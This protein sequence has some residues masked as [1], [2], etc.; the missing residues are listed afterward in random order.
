MKE[1]AEMKTHVPMNVEDFGDWYGFVI[2]TTCKTCT[3]EDYKQCPGRRVL[4]TYDV[5]AI[6]PGAVGKC[7]YSYVGTPEAEEL[8]PVDA[9]VVPAEKYNQAVAEA[10]A[11]KEQLAEVRGYLLV[12]Y[13]NSGNINPYPPQ[14]D[15]LARFANQFVKD[16]QKQVCRLTEDLQTAEKLA[17]EQAAE[18][19]AAEQDRD[20]W[21]RKSHFYAENV[22]EMKTLLD[23]QIACRDEA[24]RQVA[25]L[26][27]RLQAVAATQEQPKEQYPVS[28]GLA[29][30]GEFEYTQPAHMTEI[31][32]REIQQPKHTR[33]TC[34]QYVAGSLVAI[35]L[36]EVVA[37][38]VDKLPQ[39]DWVKQKA[40]PDVPGHVRSPTV[41]AP[42]AWV[43]SEKTR[44]NAAR[45]RASNSSGLA[46]VIS[47]GSG[48]AGY[49]VPS[50]LTVAP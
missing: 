49:T 18:L 35:D 19:E 46:R 31:M 43:S 37:L 1:L 16:L 8:Q 29:S 10:A 23:E 15:N 3:R 2:E 45:I 24:Q 38:H 32:I 11:L 17:K 5:C 36:Q 12:I 9:D 25:D 22:G 13:Q 30:G 42:P 28:I 4:S 41:N 47:P 39:G 44:R 34:A 20:E 21:M 14:I 26:Q 6:D 48:K 7:Q 27:A 33:S 50:T 40:A